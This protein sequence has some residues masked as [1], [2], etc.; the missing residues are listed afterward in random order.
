MRKNTKPDIF[1]FSEKQLARFRLEIDEAGG[2]DDLM[3]AKRALSL[4][5]EVI[6]IAKTDI[7]KYREKFV[8]G[9]YESVKEFYD[10][11]EPYDFWRD[12]YNVLVRWENGN[13]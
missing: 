2:F 12:F 6:Q 9:D 7:E 11:E 8:S 13:E 1:P 10:I 3:V 4:E 5:G